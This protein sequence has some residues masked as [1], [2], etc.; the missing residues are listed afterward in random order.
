ML[1]EVT[2]HF[3]T[4]ADFETLISILS[5]QHKTN[6]MYCIGVRKGIHYYFTSLLS[7]CFPNQI[8]S[9]C[10]AVFNTQLSLLK[11]SKRKLQLLK[12]IQFIQL[13]CKGFF[14]IFIFYIFIE[15]RQQ[16][17]LAETI[18]KTGFWY[19]EQKEKLAK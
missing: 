10:F 14:Y 17:R 18:R 4:N 7:F 19:E 6:T 3:L 5:S 12:K 13:K 2:F 16:E 9:V 1:V 11:F 8:S 15:Q